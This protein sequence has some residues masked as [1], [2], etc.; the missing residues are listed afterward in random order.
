MTACSAKSQ[1]RWPSLTLDIGAVNNLASPLFAA[2]FY[3]KTFMWPKFAWKKIYEPNIRAAAGLGHAPTEADPDHYANRFAHCDVLVIGGGLAG[4]S[5]A[6]SAAESGAETILVEQNS[7]FG[8]ALLFEN[9]IK[10]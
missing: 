5:A 4:L 7:V 3:Y 10:C 8:G 2:G 1:N 9:G 6:L